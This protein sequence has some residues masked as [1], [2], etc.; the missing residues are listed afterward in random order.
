MI[1]TYNKH[2]IMEPLASG[3]PHIFEEL[4]NQMIADIEQGDQVKIITQME[5]FPV[6][7]ITM[8]TTVEEVEIWFEPYLS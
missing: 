7:D 3:Y 4:K 8:L 6:E 2:Q 1:K 5:G